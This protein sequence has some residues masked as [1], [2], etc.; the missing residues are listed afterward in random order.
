MQNT[1]FLETPRLILRFFNKND[2]LNL[3]EL[4]SDVEV[5]RFTNLG[6][7]KGGSP[8]NTDYENIKNVTL[9][10][11]IESYGNHQYGYWAVI[12][13]ASDE[14]IGWFHLRPATENQFYF[15][16]GFYDSSEIELGYRL[17]KTA[18]NKGYATEGSQAL[19]KK[20]FVDGTQQIV[21]M[22]LATNLASIRVMEKAGLKFVG[23]Y[24]H[25]EIDQDV[26]KYALNNEDFITEMVNT[27]LQK[28]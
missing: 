28:K 25:P 14:F 5:I 2:D 11:F 20:S 27:N 19:I 13:K 9:P 8:L 16:L 4:D 12:E 24:F 18:W 22:A 6:L 17:K 23:K 1:T 3:Y 10:K 21:S 7:I 26:V 15:K